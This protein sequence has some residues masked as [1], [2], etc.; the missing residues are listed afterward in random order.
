MNKVY[1]YGAHSRAQTLGAYL[2]FIHPECEVLAYIYDNDETNPSNVSEVPVLRWSENIDLIKDVPIYIGTRGVFHRAI[3]DRLKKY[4]MEKII[5]VDAKMDMELRNQYLSKFYASIG[6][7]FEKI[8]PEEGATQGENEGNNAVIYVANSAFDKELTQSYE[9]KKYERIIQVGTALTEKRLEKAFVYDNTGDN[10]SVK[11]RQYCELTAMYWIWKN[12]EENHVG[13]AHYRRHF[14]L[15]DDWDDIMDK[16]QIDVI[17]PTPLLVMPNLQENFK[18]RHKPKVWEEMMDILWKHHPKCYD[19]AEKF[20]ST[21]GLYS[22]C[23]MFIM[24]KQILD[25]FCCWLFPM[26]EELEN[27]IGNVDDIYQNRYPGF[28]AE[29]LMTLFFEMHREQYHLVYADKNFLT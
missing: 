28:V 10:I 2:T 29:R 22:P 13:L 6:K 5:P 24:R 17:L 19:D 18:M 20:F 26:L 4:G 9:F 23:N 1:I 27:R 7:K 16:K 25:E 12:A 8:T 14:L 11:N 21:N 3:T 15:P